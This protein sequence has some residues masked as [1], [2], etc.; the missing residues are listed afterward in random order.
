MTG[1]CRPGYTTRSF[2]TRVSVATILRTD[3]YLAAT[4]LERLVLGQFSTHVFQCG[5][6]HWSSR[7]GIQFSSADML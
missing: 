5:R 6:S 2:V 4:K 1:T 7:N 3:W